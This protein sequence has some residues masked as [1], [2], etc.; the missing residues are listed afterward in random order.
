MKSII[1]YYSYTGNTKKVAEILQE[2]LRNKGDAD[3]IELTD[4]QETGKFFKQA[5]QAFR[6]AK[7]DI[8]EV[9][10]DLSTYDTICF[11]TPIWAFGPAP[12]L[13]T[14]LSK[15]FGLEAKPIVLFATYGS[16]TGLNR[17][18]DYMRKVLSKKGAK[19]FRQFSIQQFKVNNK[20][21]VLD[22][23]GYTLLLLPNSAVG[24]SA[25]GGG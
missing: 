4:L 23:I 2:Y 1:V 25:S 22:K 10:F 24:G 19:E 21:F 20:E 15:C 12:A 6:H 3:I 8:P 9:K 16:G 11:G 13:N 14:Y 17:C 18:F 7:A 5:A